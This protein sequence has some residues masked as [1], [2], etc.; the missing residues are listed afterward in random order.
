MLTSPQV[1]RSFRLA[2]RRRCASGSSGASGSA[3][4]HM[5]MH[6]H[7]QPHTHTHATTGVSRA[8]VGRCASPPRS[9]GRVST[10]TS[11]GSCANAHS[12]SASTA[13]LTDCTSGSRSGLLRTHQPPRVLPRGL[14]RPPWPFHLQARRTIQTLSRTSCPPLSTACSLARASCGFSTAAV[15]TCPSRSRSRLASPPSLSPSPSPS[16]PHLVLSF[17][18]VRCVLHLTPVRSRIRTLPAVMGNALEQTRPHGDHGDHGHDHSHSHSHSHSPFGHHHH[19]HDNTYLTSANTSD[20]GVRI[21]RLG[22]LSNL[23]MA[24]AKFI[25]GWAFNSRAMVAD[26]W[27]S[28]A[29][30]ASDILTLL[31]VSWSLKPPSDRFPMGFGKVESLGS[32]GVSGMLLVGGLY[33][34]WES[35]ISL[36]G[37]F[38]PEGAHH[39]FEHVGH[40]HSHSHSPADLGLPS[41]HAVWLAAGT[42]LIKEWLYHA[43][44]KIARERKSSVLASNAVHHRVDSLT[45]IVTL[46]AILGANIIENCAWLDPVGGLL[47]SIM[48][49]SAGYENTKEALYELADRSLD[50]EVKKSV[51]KQAHRALANVSVGHEAELRDISGIKSGQNYLVDVELAVPGAWTVDDVKDLEDAVRSQIGS[52]VRGVRRL[53]VRFVSRDKPVNEKWDEFIAGSEALQKPEGQAEEEEGERHG[54]GR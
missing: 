23:G 29:D 22:L 1:Q 13:A 44:M 30:L 14:S 36:Y 12:R 11:N 3:H 52:R 47:I 20:P 40:G 35:G 34:G 49:V 17:P 46:A 25:G 9:R 33:M 26:A 50:D 10:G 19:H 7:T 31:T 43:T 45:G 42:I 5:H 32:L 53:R 16:T 37:H 24:I 18:T 41:I 4:R 38:N 21:T 2:V 8:T 28:L 51:R 48:V 6:M 15:Y 39:I 27:H 54:R